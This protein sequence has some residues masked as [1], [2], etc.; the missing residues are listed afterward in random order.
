MNPLRERH[1]SYG[2]ERAQIGRVTKSCDATIWMIAHNAESAIWFA[3]YT[4]SCFY[5]CR[6]LALLS[7]LMP[8]ICSLTDAF[9]L[10]EGEVKCTRLDV[11]DKDGHH[12]TFRFRRSNFYS[13]I[14][15]SFETL[16]Q[17][18]YFCKK[19]PSLLYSDI[20]S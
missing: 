2:S 7:L 14:V 17:C 5:S 10:I 20:Q 9:E 3:R 15:L 18:L 8:C 19:Y 11:D 13:R 4:F 1:C 12:T 16:A 6:N